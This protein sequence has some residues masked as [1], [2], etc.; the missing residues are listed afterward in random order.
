M[1]LNE[2]IDLW[3]QHRRNTQLVVFSLVASRE[4]LASLPL[5]PKRK[6]LIALQQQAIDA[7][8]RA[9]EFSEA[10]LVHLRSVEACYGSAPAQAK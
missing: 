8:R 7:A 4:Q 9:L 5:E 10:N 6:R 2:E 1:Q 3:A